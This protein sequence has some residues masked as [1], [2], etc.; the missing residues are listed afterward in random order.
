MCPGRCGADAATPRGVCGASGDC[1][2]FSGFSG[3][4]CDITSGEAQLRLRGD[5]YSLNANALLGN[6]TEILLG[7]LPEDV[8]A[9][10]N[11]TLPVVGA[12]PQ[13]G[14][15]ATLA[16]TVPVDAA[17]P[18]AVAPGT[19]GANAQGN[20]TAASILALL[21]A[22]AAIPDEALLV[23]Q[24]VAVRAASASGQPA[25]WQQVQAPC[26]NDCSGRGVCQ[27]DLSCLCDEGFKGDDCGIAPAFLK[28]PG[29]CSNNGLC[30]QGKCVCDSGW[31]GEDCA[32]LRR[33]CPGNCGSDPL[34]GACNTTTGVCACTEQ[35][36]GEDCGQK[37]CLQ[38]CVEG[39][40]L[41]GKCEC[42]PGYTGADCSERVCEPRCGTGGTCVSGTCECRKGWNGELC[43]VQGCPSSCSSHGTC[44]RDGDGDGKHDGDSASAP[45]MCACEPGYR[46]VAC[47]ARVELKC[48]DGIDNDEDGVADCDDA[49]CCS[50]AV[51]ADDESCKASPPLADLVPPEELEV[52][53]TE[54]AKSFLESRA[55]L[56]N[57]TAASQFNT[58]LDAFEEESVAVV[59]GI[60]TDRQGI[61]L[62]GVRV[63]IAGAPELGY[64]LTRSD[65]TYDMLVNG[66]GTLNVDFARRNY[67]SSQRTPLVPELTT[68]AVPEVAM[69]PVSRVATKVELG[70]ASGNPEVLQIASSEQSQDDAGGTVRRACCSRATPWP[71][72]SLPT[73]RRCPWRRPRC[74]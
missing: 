31:S 56:V 58:T 53:T 3:D 7:A 11:L 13:G 15:R 39:L 10:V 69:M 20:V 72:W 68:T 65:G 73:A 59:Q 60:V 43:D 41:N 4:A 45:W 6:L 16:V 9:A 37:L 49:D 27:R 48:G 47:Q 38:G 62:P 28:C 55:F 57:G 24:V 44:I 63:S 5:V 2:C 17:P 67:I 46:G 14:L 22:R 25:A 64:T 52:P 71:R 8:A 51:C 42:D 18:G 29:D 30:V 61:P 54:G 23:S 74:V 40:C 32:T 1:V 21:A 66:G 33:A 35:Y 36:G 70:G 12:D 19:A 26:P 50:Q 34:R